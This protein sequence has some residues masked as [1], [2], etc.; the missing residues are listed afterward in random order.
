[1]VPDV[2]GAINGNRAAEQAGGERGENPGSPTFVRGGDA[3]T[4]PM[5]CWSGQA[6]TNPPGVPLSNQQHFQ[7]EA[8]QEAGEGSEGDMLVAIRKGVKLKRT[9]TNDR[10]APRIA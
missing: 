9:L 10:S 3:D 5:M 1:M 4:L 2:S 8:G 6:T 7:C